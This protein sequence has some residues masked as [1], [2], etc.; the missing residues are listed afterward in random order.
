MDRKEAESKRASAWW[1]TAK[2]LHVPPP[3]P[4]TIF[5][6][7]NPPAVAADGAPSVHGCALSSSC[8]YDCTSEAL[9]W[10]SVIHC[11]IC[12]SQ[13]QQAGKP[14]SYTFPQQMLSKRVTRCYHDRQHPPTP[15]QLP[16]KHISLNSKRVKS[17]LRIHS[18]RKQQV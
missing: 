9:S 13:I 3:P 17:S 15:T 18:E 8:S 7:V 11:S 2:G 16:N 1:S 10:I 14:S 12:S 4:Y 6:E 5:L